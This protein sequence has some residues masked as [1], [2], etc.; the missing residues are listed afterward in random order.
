M[1]LFDPLDGSSNTDVN[2]PLGSIF[3]I[4]EHQHPDQPPGDNDLLRKGT[5]QL[6][7]GYF[8]FGPSTMLVFTTGKGRLR[9]YARSQRRGVSIVSSEASRCLH[10]ERYTP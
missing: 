6:A 9:V 10:A 2:M 8:L 1:V 3:S 7:A 5:H 4:V